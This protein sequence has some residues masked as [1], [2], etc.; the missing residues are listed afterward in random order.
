MK[1]SSPSSAHWRSSNTRTTTPCSAMRSKKRRQ[2]AKSDSR[3]GR[4][5]PSLGSRPSSWS[6]RGSI[7]RRSASSG[8]HS[9][10]RRC[11]PRPRGGRVVAV[12]DPD[13]APDHLGE[14][15]EADPD[16]VGRRPAL[17]PVDDLGHAVEVLLELPD[18]PALADP[19]LADDR[20]EPRPPLGTGREVEVLEHPQLRSAADERRLELLDPARPAAPGD[21]PQRAVGRDRRGLALEQLLARRLEGDRVRCGLVG[22]LADEDGPRRRHRLEA[23][24]GVDEVAGDHPLVRRAEGHRRLAGQHAGAQPELRADLVARGPRP[25]RPGRARCG[26]RARRRPRRRSG[27]PTRPSPRRR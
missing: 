19:A 8:T 14:C 10:E 22:R 23:R 9:L 17:V 21:D 3:S 1:S 16:A 5:A 20:D 24:R 7:Q 6:R 18:Q 12:G 27:R 26:P 4:S 13:P 2:A 11:Q 15:P 25:R